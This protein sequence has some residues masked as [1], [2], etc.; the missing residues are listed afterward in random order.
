MSHQIEHL[1]IRHI[2]T[3]Y[4]NNFFSAKKN[5]SRVISWVQK[6]LVRRQMEP[7][8]SS[9]AS[10]RPRPAQPAPLA[11]LLGRAAGPRGG[12]SVL[13]RG[14]AAL[15]LQERRADWAYSRPVVVLDIAWNLVFTAASAAVLCATTSERPNTPVRVWL[16]GYALQ[17]LIHVVFVWG[18]YRRRRRRSGGESRLEGG[19]GDGEQTLPESDAMDS[20]DDAAPPEVGSGRRASIAKRCESINTMAS[21]IWW[22]VGFC[23]VVSGGEALLKNAP[24]LYWLTVVFLTFD[25]LFAIFCIALA[26]IIGIALCC[27]LPCVIAILCAVIGQEGASDSDISILPRYRYSEPCGD[28]QKTFKE[29]LM[30]PI[31]NNHD[32]STGERVLL[33]EDAVKTVVYV[34]LH[35]KME[36][37]YL[38]FPAIIISTLHALSN[39]FVSMQL[40]LFANITSS[41]ADHTD[42]LE[43]A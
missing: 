40:A 42:G 23:W 19:G 4:S 34:F 35:M 43:S 2:T 9:S 28:G 14:T 22:I 24:T 1:L 11:A 32:I 41:M 7:Q 39:G 5:P 3:N 26:C 16:L 21:F 38:L 13:V 10:V 12:P 33:R 20:E 31:L 25:A 27:C 29:G 6:K 15:H 30:V 37:Y 17:C 36:H 8:E 18:E